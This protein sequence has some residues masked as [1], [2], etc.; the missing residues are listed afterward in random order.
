ML[1]ELFMPVEEA[2]EDEDVRQ[3]FNF[4]PGYH[5]LVY[6]ADTPDSGAGSRPHEDGA[7][8]P[9][10]HRD[11]DKQRGKANLS[12]GPETST[13]HYK[14]QAM[15]WGMHDLPRYILPEAL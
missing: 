15:K 6:R 2:P 4:A 14:L 10:G 13:V 11:N 12:G 9:D 5:G 1:E 7:Q 8:Q 3:S